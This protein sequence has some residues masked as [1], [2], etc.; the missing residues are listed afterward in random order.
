MSQPDRSCGAT[1]SSELVEACRGLIRYW[2]RNL[3]NFQWEKA[4]THVKRINIALGTLSATKL[5]KGG[6]ARLQDR[7]SQ[8]ATAP[9]DG[10]NPSSAADAAA[11]NELAPHEYAW[12]SEYGAD[13]ALCGGGIGDDIHHA[14]SAASETPVGTDWKA[15]AERYRKGMANWKATAEAKDTEIID[16]RSAL[17]TSRLCTQE[18]DRRVQ[19]LEGRLPSAERVGTAMEALLSA[20]ESHKEGELGGWELDL[21]RR[22]LLAES[23]APSSARRTCPYC[24]SDNPAIRSTYYDQTCE[25]CVKRMG[26]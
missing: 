5:M 19:E 26:Q 23:S 8:T 2:T 6:S 25:G 20:I 4:D 12:D 22:R 11:A 21:V 1:H 24:T 13:C 14:P 15:E 7:A 9:A 16:L 10:E 3:Q 17:D 18:R